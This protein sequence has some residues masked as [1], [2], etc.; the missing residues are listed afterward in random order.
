MAGKPDL[1]GLTSAAVIAWA[2]RGDWLAID[3]HRIFV[4]DIPAAHDAT[5]DPLF[6]LH[7][8]PSSSFDW[9]SVVDHMANGRRVVLFDFLGCGLSDKPD[10]RYR[11]EGHA[12]VASAVATQLGLE[13]AVI[14]SHDIGD[15]VAGELLEIGRAHV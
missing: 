11:L 13:R 6:V 3:G 5:S 4:V 14:V 12:D 9:H 8:F 2:D 15:S 1:Q 7:G 10:Q